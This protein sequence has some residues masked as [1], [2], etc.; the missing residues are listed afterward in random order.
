MLNWITK[1][2]WHIWAIFRN[3]VISKIDIKNDY[4]KDPIPK[5]LWIERWYTQHSIVL[6]KNDQQ[7]TVYDSYN[8]EVPVTAVQCIQIQNVRK[9]YS[10]ASKLKFDTIK[11][12]EKR[13]LY[14]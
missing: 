12:A 4:S 10:I 6:D 2:R 13:K 14:K 8:T 9:T 3:S 7:L 5:I 1:I 11:S